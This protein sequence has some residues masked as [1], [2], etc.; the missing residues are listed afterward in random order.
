MDSH[1]L[2]RA[3]LAHRATDVRIEVVIDGPGPA[4]D[5]QLVYLR[6][7]PEDDDIRIPTSSVVFYHPDADAMVIRAGFVGVPSPEAQNAQ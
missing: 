6:D 4:Y 2:A 7:H 1:E 3:L 5:R